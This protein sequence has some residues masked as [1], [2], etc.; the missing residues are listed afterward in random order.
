M[1][2][3]LRANKRGILTWIIVGG[4]VFIFG[5]NFGPG[6]LSRGNGGGCSGGQA[7]FAA[8]VNGETIQPL[9]FERAYQ[10]YFNLFQGQMGGNLP[11]ELARQLGL[12]QRAL[13]YVVERE[14]VVQ[15][16]R[17]RGLVVTDEEVASALHSDP[18][19]QL[20]GLFDAQTYRETARRIAGSEGRYEED[21][22]EEQL[23]RR[24][25]ASVEQ[26]VKVSDA[27]VRDE[28]QRESDR[29]ALS[30]VL[31]PR[32]AFEAAV[33]PTEAEVKAFADANGEAV[34]R[35]HEENRA[36]FDEKKRVRV[37]H[38]LAR[39]G[40]Q[41]PE[42]ARK[43][44]EDAA[45]RVKQGEDFAAVVAALSEDENTR[46]RG[47]DLGFVS[48]G[49]FDEAFAKAAL[50][51]EPGQVSEPVQSASGWHLVKAEE[52]VPART[53]PLEAARLLIARELLVKD[54]AAKAAR[55]RAEAALASARAGKPLAE[56]FP[57]EDAEKKKT[58]VTVAGKPLVAQ[59]TGTF[60][61]GT[62][63]APRLGAA[64][65]LLADAFAAKRGDV[66]PEVYETPEGLAVATVVARERPD[67]SAFEQASAAVRARLRSEAGMQVMTAWMKELR[68]G[69]KI[70]LNPVYLA[71]GAP[72]P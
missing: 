36:R 58:P 56:L 57:A 65:A 4:I 51:L 34:K 41:G 14:L 37:R 18:A 24:M 11:E 33:K 39:V 22:R 21:L 48:E 25:L 26:T 64:P 13:D 67:P 60:T 31:F 17:R 59:E 3:S 45:A 52:V 10:Q 20:N 69:A 66:L 44:I 55:A 23:Y 61:A 19:F 47:G 38:V 71:G 28:W 30:F 50:A 72:Q 29:V 9:E 27:E 5:V 68:A 32:A 12:G 62:E 6:S 16:A 40:A 8:K 54:R 49:L 53:V 2:D 15:E 70:E 42:A 46:D 1:L 7:I 43:K 35:F 63:L